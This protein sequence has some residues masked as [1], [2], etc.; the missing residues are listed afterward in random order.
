[1]RK[2]S[3]ILLFFLTVIPFI[4][5]GCGSSR[6]AVMEGMPTPLSPVTESPVEMATQNL[7]MAE[8]L[9]DRPRT[10]YLLGPEDAVEISVFRHDDLKME[11]T[12]SPMGRISYYLVD[13]IQAAG[14]TQFQLRDRIQQ[15][16][17]KFI[18][19]PE[20]VVR[21]TEHRARRR[22]FWARLPILA[23]FT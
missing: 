9:K 14:M 3:S 17:T 15:E 10:E 4:L 6:Q 18:K 11:T 23:C 20:V 1:M 12:V 2:S 13:D 16:L 19:D 5:G 22:L 8:R 21:I 7:S